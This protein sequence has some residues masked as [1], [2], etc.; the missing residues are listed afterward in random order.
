MAGNQGSTQRLP[1][2]NTLVSNARGTIY[3]FAP[4][5]STVWSMSASCSK[6]T[7]YALTYLDMIT[8][9]QDKNGIISKNQGLH[10]HSN[11]TTGAVHISLNNGI[12]NT[13]LQIFTLNGQEVFSGIINSN[14]YIWNT[15]NQSNGLYLV[16]VTAGNNSISRYIH[17]VR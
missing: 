8:G 13:K 16:R 11:P 4:N 2:G 15:H 9:T 3:E 6:A 12:K 17:M 14:N 7:R 5:G 10:V 1:N